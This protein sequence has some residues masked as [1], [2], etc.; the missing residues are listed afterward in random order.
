MFHYKCGPDDEER[1]RLEKESNRIFLDA[2][3]FL[4][5]VLSKIN[6]TF[7]SIDQSQLT[8]IF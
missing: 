3:N 2:P 8:E 6:A 7:Y 4:V 5:V 1:V